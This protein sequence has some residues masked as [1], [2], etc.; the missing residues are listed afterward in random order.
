[1]KTCLFS[2]GDKHKTLCDKYNCLLMAQ[3]ITYKIPE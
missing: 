2:A 3:K 1:M